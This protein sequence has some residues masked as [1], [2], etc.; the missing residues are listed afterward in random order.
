MG[1]L[2]QTGT[3]ST[4]ATDVD[5]VVRTDPNTVTFSAN[6]TP[7]SEGLAVP[8][9]SSTDAN[10]TW[11]VDTVLE[12]EGVIINNATFADL[13]KNRIYDWF[14][15]VTVE[16]LVGWA[17]IPTATTV[18]V[19]VLHYYLT[20][21]GVTVH[22][23]LRTMKFTK[24]SSPWGLKQTARCVI[25]CKAG[26]TNYIGL[27]IQANDLTA[28]TGTGLSVTAYA[29]NPKG[30]G[31]PDF[32]LSY[33]NITYWD[34]ESDEYKKLESP[35]V[36]FISLFGKCKV[37][38]TDDPNA[39]V[40]KLWGSNFEGFDGA[41]LNRA[42]LHMVAVCAASG[43]DANAAFRRITGDETFEVA[44]LVPV[45][46]WPISVSVSPSGAV[47]GPFKGLTKDKIQQII[48][49]L[50]QMMKVFISAIKDASPLTRDDFPAIYGTLKA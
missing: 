7:Y 29:E 22:R 40:P 19:H 34:E 49:T 41:V 48:T 14:I 31:K 26:T 8:Q 35:D 28:W 36:S 37:Y 33:D 39:S 46:R 11:R 16:A 23:G 25:P 21:D 5:A 47:D 3:G 45:S 30:Y 4:A 38:P 18:T 27:Y 42:L 43:I 20:E 1:V 12:K 2:R 50:M 15:P 44:S 13:P 17:V 24:G 32:T 10:V 9:A 6:T